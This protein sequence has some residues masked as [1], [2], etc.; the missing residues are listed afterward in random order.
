MPFFYFFYYVPVK[1]KK[2]CV[3]KYICS[4]HTFVLLFSPSRIL[5]DLG[6]IKRRKKET[7]EQVVAWP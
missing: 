1:V 2:H 6:A 4:P 3:E 5:I 7:R